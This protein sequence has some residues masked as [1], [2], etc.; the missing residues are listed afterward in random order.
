MTGTVGVNSPDTRNYLIGKGFLLFKPEGDSYYYH[1][2]N[3]PEFTITP[4]VET[5]EHFSSME[6]T[7]F[8][9][10]TIVLEKGGDIRIVM[11]E[12]TAKNIALLM[13]GTV[14]EDEYGDVSID[15]FSRTSF[16]GAL[17]FYATNEKGPRWKIDLPKVVFN[18]SGPFNPISNEIAQLEA[19]GK[20]TALD[21][22][23]GTMTL[24]A[25][26]GTRAPENVLVPVIAGLAIKG[27]E[28]YAYHGGWIDASSF[29][30]VWKRDNVAIVGATERTYTTV[31]AD[32][33]KVITVTVTATNTIGS[34]S[35]T[36]L[37]TAAIADV[38]S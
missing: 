29:T 4:S 38:E 34:A 36:S 35:A 25:P 19:T 27:E 14:S 23:F 2:G 31:T 3:C 1:M 17:L 13:L 26:S 20:W 30:Y 11:E 18:P 37:G 15:L 22:D 5:L 24:K 8:N 6:G 21:G 12:I 32:L 10:D 33:T 7:R 9:D 16:T 28:L